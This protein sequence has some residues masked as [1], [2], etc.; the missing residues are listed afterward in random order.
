MVELAGARPGLD[1]D[2]HHQHMAGTQPVKTM[3]KEK[4]GRHHH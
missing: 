1:Q 4:A 3:R 2:G